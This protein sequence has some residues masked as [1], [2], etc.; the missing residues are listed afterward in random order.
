[1]CKD[2]ETGNNDF[3]FIYQDSTP[4][5]A[6]NNLHISSDGRQ[7]YI[8]DA[9]LEDEGRYSCFA[10]NPAGIFEKDFYVN[11]IGW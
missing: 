11:V 7:I 10:L 4:I 1:M 9:N 6:S 3:E 2:V 5:E 8:I